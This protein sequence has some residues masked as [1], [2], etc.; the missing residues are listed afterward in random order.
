M[1]RG[2]GNQ[3]RRKE[4]VESELIGHSFM[5][6]LRIGFELSRFADNSSDLWKERVEGGLSKK[7]LFATERRFTMGEKMTKDENGGG[8]VK[9]RKFLQG[10]VNRV[11]WI[12]VFCG[13]F[14]AMYTWSLYKQYNAFLNSLP[15]LLGVIMLL[16]LFLFCSLAL[17]VCLFGIDI[18]LKKFLEILIISLGI[19]NVSRS[20]LSR[21]QVKMFLIKIGVGWFIFAAFYYCFGEKYNSLIRSLPDWLLVLLSLGIGFGFFVLFR[22]SYLSYKRRMQHR[23]SSGEIREKSPKVP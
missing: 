7:G 13:A 21:N 2:S 18:L 20:G 22:R 19:E 3:A 9:E 5:D 1:A 4:K 23:S 10:H 11:W 6:A 12:G 8:N 15:T 16:G 17:R 14:S